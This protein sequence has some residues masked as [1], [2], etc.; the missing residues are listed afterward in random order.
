MNTKFYSKDI[1][2]FPSTIG[3][4]CISFINSKSK[5]VYI[6][7]A[8]R[9]TSKIKS[10]NGFYSR[11]RKHLHLLKINKHHSSALQN[12]YNKYGVDNISFIVLE[13]CKPTECVAKEQF[14]INLY[15]SYLK[16]YNGRPLSNN[17]L[18]FKQSEKQK[19]TIKNK[20]KKIR[21]S[22]YK[23]IKK[24]YDNNKTTR[25]ISDILHISRTFIRRVFKENNI[26]GKNTA[27]YKKKKL[28]QYKLNGDF[29]KEWNNINLCCFNLQ[30]KPNT[31]RD[32]TSG[33]SKHAGGFYFSLKKLTPQEVLS[34]I[35]TLTIKSKN[36]KYFDIKQFDENKNYIK[37]WRDIK[38]IVEYFKFS[39]TFGIIRV[40]TGQRETYKGFYWKL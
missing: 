27:H 15:N 31:I 3:V 32:V 5:K 39:N 36:R 17:N 40:I 33:R 12:A 2:N 9:N 22:Y 25:E 30:I 4:Y 24:L 8:S 13:E 23:K 19:N 7:S 21:D 11:W 1:K 26:N 6:G 29:I 18:G 14:Y 28:F 38:E 16:G 35:N 10:G 37:T 34:N 20:Y